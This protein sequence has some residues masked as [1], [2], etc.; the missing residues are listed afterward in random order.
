ML[1]PCLFSLSTLTGADHF[2]QPDG[3]HFF[4]F[5]NLS[6]KSSTAISSRRDLGMRVSAES[7]SNLYSFSI[8]KF[9]YPISRR[10]TGNSLVGQRANSNTQTVNNLFQ[11]SEYLVMESA[12]SEFF[13]NL[14]DRIHFRCI[15]RDMKKNDI[16][17]HIQ[18]T[19]LVPRGTITAK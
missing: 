3:V 15:W 16:I 6:N 12:L 8:K 4:C 1:L 13:P 17:W 2:V 5:S 11:G 14:L 18:S 10:D 19:G 7:W 9:N